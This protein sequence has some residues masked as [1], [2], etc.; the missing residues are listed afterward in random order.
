[1]PVSNKPRKKSSSSSVKTELISLPNPMT[2]EKE[3]K[4]FGA[5]PEDEAIGEAQDLVY[6]AWEA[7]DGRSR[8]ALAHRH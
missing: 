6:E 1:M 8:Y 3:W 5:G 7:A 4:K 2:L